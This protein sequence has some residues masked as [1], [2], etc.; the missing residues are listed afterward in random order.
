MRAAVNGIYSPLQGF[1]NNQTRANTWVPPNLQM[2]DM[3][4]DNARYFYNPNYR[5]VNES[6]ADFIPE[7]QMFSGYWNNYYS[8]ISR[9]NQVLAAID[10]EGIE[11]DSSAVKDNLKGQA[12][13]VRAWSYYWLATLYGDAC[14]HLEPV[15]TLDQS[16]VALSPE[17]EIISIVK[18]DA[19]LAQSLLL[20]KADQQAG[21][22]TSG[23]ATMLL[24]EVAI[25]EKDY[26]TA[27][28]LLKSLS[29]EYSLMPNYADC[30]DPSMKKQCRINLR[31]SV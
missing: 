12:L 22:I 1:Y 10:D 14:I 15:A 17:S 13:F 26:G 20:G 4:S 9:C 29:S 19:G 31:N 21:R 23:T 8:W 18:T 27:E 6:P 7:N 24:A 25:Y 5:A 11:W 30:F 28:T 16:S 2:G 3:H